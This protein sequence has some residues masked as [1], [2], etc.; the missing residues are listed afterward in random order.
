V[1]Y[2][3]NALAKRPSTGLP[4]GGEQIRGVIFLE[5]GL[6]QHMHWLNER[7]FLIA[8]AIGMISSGPVV[9]TATFVGYLVAARLSGSLLEGL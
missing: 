7:D 3:L 8:V 2:R 1:A 4:Q 6:V 9:I 5:K